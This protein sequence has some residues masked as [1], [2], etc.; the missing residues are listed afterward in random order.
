MKKVFLLM[1]LLCSSSAW[2]KPVE[3]N[4]SNW[5]WPFID[6]KRK[7]ELDQFD[8]V[9]S[10]G[11]VRSRGMILELPDGSQWLV[12]PLGKEATSFWAQKSP[13]L[14][15]DF[16]ENQVKKWRPGEKII[17]HKVC[18]NVSEDDEKLKL[19]VYNVDRDQLFDVKTFLPPVEPSLTL[20]NVDPNQKT[21]ELSDG[22]IWQFAKMCTCQEWQKG[23]P[24][25]VA[26]NTPWRS[27][28]THILANLSIC[29]CDSTVEHIHANTLGV[30][31]IK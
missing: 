25:I 23:D 13:E 15:F 12:E 10:V 30:I 3:L 22:S 2:S 19:L 18:N 6:T 8:Y 14:P 11:Q 24:I 9:Y 31:R 16:I 4:T 20:V 27:K 28:N 26:K 29:E 7:V 1:V 17:F 5:R 21:L